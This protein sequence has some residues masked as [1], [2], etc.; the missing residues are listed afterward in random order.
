MQKHKPEI[1]DVNPADESLR[2]LSQD[3]EHTGD[4]VKKGRHCCLNCGTEI[5]RTT[6]SRIPPC[7]RCG[8]LTF[9]TVEE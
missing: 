4:V 1:L 8:N 6:K 9:S 2:T 3:T 5:P 7:P